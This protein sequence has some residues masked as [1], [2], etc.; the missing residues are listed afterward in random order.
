MKRLIRAGGKKICASSLDAVKG[1]TIGWRDRGEGPE[2]IGTDPGDD[3]PESFRKDLSNGMKEISM[4]PSRLKKLRYFSA[5]PGECALVALNEL[6]GS[7]PYGI[8]F[9]RLRKKV[10]D[11]L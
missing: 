1:A 4:S 3:R 10:Q 8:S 7:R 2:K 9:L 6:P 11:T 5:H